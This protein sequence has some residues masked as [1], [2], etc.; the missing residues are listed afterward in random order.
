MQEF[1]NMARAFN[2]CEATTDKVSNNADDATFD[3]V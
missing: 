1:G 3:K 2:I